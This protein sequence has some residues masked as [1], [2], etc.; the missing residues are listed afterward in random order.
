MGSDN[1]GFNCGWNVGRCQYPLCLQKTHAA[2][3]ASV[4]AL[5]LSTVVDRVRLLHGEPEKRKGEPGVK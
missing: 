2:G 5:C 4:R 3:H 1:L